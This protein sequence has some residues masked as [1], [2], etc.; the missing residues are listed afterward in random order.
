ML[1]LAVLPLVSRTNKPNHIMKKLFSLLA[2]GL[3][4][5]FSSCQ[6][7]PP[8][9]TETTT[10]A[11]LEEEEPKAADP[12]ETQ[13]EVMVDHQ[14][15][16]TGNTN[17][18]VYFMARIKGGADTA[19]RQ[20]PPLNISMVIDRSGSMSSEEKLSNAK[21]AVLMVLDH[22]KAEDQVS[23]VSYD[24][25]VAVV[26]P[27]GKLEMKSVLETKV[28]QIF[29][30]GSTN[31][32]GGMLEGYSQV[33]STMLEKAVNRILLLSDGLAN[34]GITDQEE[35]QKICRAKFDQEKMA[36]STF[37]IGSDFNE[38]LMTNLA[39]YGR[40]NYY[41]ISA[42]D[43]IPQIFKQ[44]LD[45]L[46]SV[47]AQNTH[48]KINFPVNMLDLQKVYGYDASVSGNAISI[49][50]NDVFAEE[51]KVV[52]IKF[53][54]KEG[55]SENL[56]FQAELQFDDVLNGYARKTEK[57]NLEMKPTPNQLAYE[58]SANAEVLK[59]IVAFTAIDN[60]ERVAALVDEG[61][62]DEA[63]E[64]MSSNIKFME[65]NDIYNIKMDSTL[66]KQLEGYK[67]YSES[68][69]EVESMPASNRKQMQKSN[70]SMNYEYKKKKRK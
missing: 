41:F 9:T 35:L 15:Y 38:D 28:N 68:L 5:L 48:L 31:L 1:N 7:T 46:L 69:D 52:L 57:L 12:S 24:D 27:S 54:L 45:G 20:R 13:F 2:T 30:G 22:L 40:G 18:E 33:K 29:S 19:E 21:E 36:I 53:Q 4:M 43:D 65:Q 64:L 6:N 58:E 67:V 47:V 49:H 37:G 39:E 14:F 10:L 61:K 42:A 66:V 8:E 63:R 70:K 59:N 50:F 11:L 34:Q 44:E 56:N 62:F 16:F 26:K 32:S 55:V 25:E 60:V 23:I 51:E 3:V 17:R